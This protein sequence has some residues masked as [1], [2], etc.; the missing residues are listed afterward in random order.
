[1][2][3]KHLRAVV[4]LALVLS[5]V[6][7]GIVAVISRA[8]DT[9]PVVSGEQ[10]VAIVSGTDV[11]AVEAASVRQPR[12]GMP[13]EPA[14]DAEITA[15]AKTTVD[16]EVWK[17]VSYRAK[18]GAICAGVTWPG[19][20]QE[21]GC[22]T[23]EQWF[24]QG[25]VSASVG[26]Q[27]AHGQLLTWQTFVLS[28]LADLSRVKTIEL[29]STNCSKRE[30][31]T[32]SGG[33]FLDVTDSASIARGIWPYEVLGEDATGRIVQRINVEP[34]PPDTKEAHAAGIKAPTVGAECA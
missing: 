3:R 10:L 18:S 19:Q 24:A 28:G 25:P 13:S 2:S 5:T 12:Q 29:V 14:A 31:V 26:A 34:R 15:H 17:I 23:M 1:M 7:V 8:A 20:G 16:G 32:D 9:T 30:L 22:N 33:F 21:M 27:Q 6:G 11:S 4:P